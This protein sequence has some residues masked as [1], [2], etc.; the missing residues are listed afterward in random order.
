[1]PHGNK[2]NF[3]LL[4]QKIVVEM[5]RTYPGINPV[6]SEWRS[7]EITDF[8]EELRHKV[9][10]HISEKWFYNHFKKESLALPRI[11]MLNLLSRY[12]GYLN[13][14]DFHYRNDLKTDEAVRVNPDNLIP[15]KW[16]C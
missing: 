9:N 7:Q 13:W 10:A 8:Q 2:N 5:Q 11:D 1:L 14:D 6:I 3:E 16:L 4:K 12:T 15:V